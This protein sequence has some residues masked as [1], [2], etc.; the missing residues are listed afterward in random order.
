M[1]RVGEELEEWEVVEEPAFPEP[2]EQETE[3]TESPE[4]E[5]EEVPA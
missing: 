4:R 3:T 1:A 5:L 2:E